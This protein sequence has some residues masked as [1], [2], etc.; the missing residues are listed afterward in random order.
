MI[1][2]T[3]NCGSSSVKFQLYAWEKRQVLAVGK[4]ERIGLER[5]A[6]TC[7]GLDRPVYTRLHLRAAQHV[8]PGGDGLRPAAGV[9]G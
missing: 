7:R 4:V 2:L 1:I 5:S 6:V 9:P 8:L 3:L